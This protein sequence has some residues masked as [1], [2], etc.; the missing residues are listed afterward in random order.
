MKIEVSNGEILDKYSILDIK[1]SRIFDKEKIQNIQNEYES[2]SENVHEIFRMVKGDDLVNLYDSLLEI[3]Q[4]LWDIEDVCRDL[5]RRKE[6]GDEFVKTAR[7]VYFTND[8]RS[9][10]KK[11]INILTGSTLVEEKGYEEY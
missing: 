3:N 6:F 7:A 8:E 1:L 4:K 2:L 5:E 11:K 10:I 9:E